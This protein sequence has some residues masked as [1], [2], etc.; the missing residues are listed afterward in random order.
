MS[1]IKKD[2]VHSTKGHI[3]YSLGAIPSA[4]P[5]NMVS[6]FFVL[7]YVSRT[8]LTLGHAGLIL[9]F[10]GIW[11]A[12][13][14]P[15]IG[16]YMDK[17]KTKW[18]RRVPYIVIGTIPFTIGFI[19]L[20]WVPWNE[21]TFVFFYAL[22]MLFL[23]DIGF[24][25]VMTAW[26]ALYVEMYEDNK[27]RSSI[28]AIKDSI[29][30]LS[31]MIGILIP[32]MIA[33]AMGWAFAGL[34]IGI[35][36]PIAMLLSLLGTREKKEYQIDQPLPVFKAFKETFTNKPFVII[37]LTYAILDFGFNLTT[38]ILPFFAR[39]ILKLDE[40][41]VGF[42]AIG[43]ALGLI[44]SIPF[45]M[46]I[47]GN[48]GPKY[49]LLLAMGIFSIGMIPM[50]FVNDF[51]SLIII[52]LLPGFGAGGLIMTEPAI[53]AAIDYDEIKTGKR[54]EATYTGIMSFVARLAIVFTGITLIL[55]QVFTGFDAEATVQPETAEVGIKLLISLVPSI[56]LLCAILV[57]YFFP[58]NLVEF[59]KMQG[60]L[61]ILHEKRL[62]DLENR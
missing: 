55:I 58:L 3:F 9:A 36:I 25:L 49:G 62:R 23:Y 31:S 54:R 34:I 46:K 57:F 52:S 7:F 19:L 37:T 21:T 2:K 38:T 48:K 18:G 20:W 27:E 14:D 30:F 50:F 39:F 40:A 44:V 59:N 8:G 32:P 56:A 1:E 16:Y 35:T 47:Y 12:I 24:T 10:Y 41:W 42:A 5:Y 61:K 11:N 13:N 15:L 51:F 26:S 4:L 45:W 22:A 28:V 33:A 6:T 53:S 60:E 17:K 29:A 43:V